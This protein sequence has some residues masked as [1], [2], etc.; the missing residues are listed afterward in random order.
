MPLLVDILDINSE[1]VDGINGRIRKKAAG[2]EMH[3]DIRERRPVTAV[4]AEQDKMPLSS[5]PG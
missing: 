4:T 2:R 5:G 3:T 1:N